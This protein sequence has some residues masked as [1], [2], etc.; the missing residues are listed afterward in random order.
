MSRKRL[1]IL[2]LTLWIHASGMAVGV[3]AAQPPPE[4]MSPGSSEP[5]GPSHSVWQDVA[6]VL[7][8]R[9]YNTRVVLLGTTLLGMSCGIIGTWMLLRKRALLGD[10]LS[11][12][13]LP[14][15]GAA[16]IV[17][18]W[19]GY[20]GKSLP[21]LLLGALVSGTAGMGC[22]LL[23]RRTSRLK[24]DAALGIVLSVFFGMGIA[25]LGIVQKMATGHAAG[26]ESF[27]YGKTASMLA[28]DAVLIGVAGAVVAALSVALFKEFTVLCFDTPFAGAQGWPVYRLDAVLMLLVIVVTV[29]GLQAVGLILMVALLVIPPAAARFW[30]HRLPAT[31]AVSATIGATSAYIGAGFSALIPNLPAGAIIVLVASSMFGV[32]LL[33]GPAR[34]LVMRTWR[35][36]RLSRK[37]GRQH[38][39]RALFESVEPSSTKSS[40]MRE[41]G[42]TVADT[43]FARLLAARSWSP[44]QLRRLLAWARRE[45]HLERIDAANYRLTDC[46]WDAA[47][48]VA[49]NHR[50]WELYLITHADIA[51]SHVDRDADEVEH[52]L[53]PTILEELE[54]I[55]ADDDARLAVPPSPH[56]LMTR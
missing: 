54:A 42:P 45:G 38:L 21:G 31:V 22:V 19:L 37:V 52:V 23:I 24:E 7:S 44:R 40:M 25:L 36:Y 48:R 33:F 11:H 10:A 8:L 51:P 15:I 47:R 35:H 14:G 55:L 43:T 26:L 34:G 17:M 50:L 56:V 28:Q 20:S 12:A 29:I 9:D 2:A 1:S 18:T 53:S 49:R 16:F 6:R 27:I 3:C 41:P 32:S 5:V 39:L 46:G 13:T 4:V 30:T